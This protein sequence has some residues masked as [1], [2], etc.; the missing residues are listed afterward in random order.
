MPRKDYFLHLFL[1]PVYLSFYLIWSEDLQ[2]LYWLPHLSFVMLGYVNKKWLALKQNNRKSQN[3]SYYLH[4]PITR[5]ACWWASVWHDE[6]KYFMKRH[7]AQLKDAKTQKIRS[8]ANTKCPQT[9]WKWSQEAK[10]IRK[11]T[12]TTQQPHLSLS[13]GSYIKGVGG[14]LSVCAQG[15]ILS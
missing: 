9:V 4:G 1:Q 14:L 2:M 10:N 5:K 3:C 6:C 13:G 12:K 15:P 11:E 8:K 7:E